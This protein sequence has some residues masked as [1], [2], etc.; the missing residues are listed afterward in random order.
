MAKI[1][2]LPKASKVNKADRLTIL[3]D[4]KVKTITKSSLLKD[5]EAKISRLAG[6]LKT[7]NKTTLAH[8]VSKNSPS[9]TKPVKGKN[10][11]SADHLSTKSYVDKN[12]SHMIRKDGS[13]PLT[14]NLSYSNKSEFS[15]NDLVDKDFVDTQLK[16]TLKKIQA[17][18]GKNGYPQASAGDVILIDTNYNSFATDGPEIQGGDILI[19]LSDSTGGTHGEVGNQFAIVNTNVVLATE[20][21]AG[22][23]K[24]STAQEI[25]ELSSDDSVI[26]PLKLKNVIEATAAYNRTEVV[27]SSYVLTEKDRGVIGVDSRRNGVTLTLPAINSLKN[28]KL[29]KYRIKDEYKSSVKYP[30]IIK[31]SSSDTIQGN[32]FFK[33]SS[34][35]GSIKL[36]NNGTDR[37]FI[38]NNLPT[39][40]DALK[41]KS[42]LTDNT[43]TGERVAA[44]AT[45]ETLMSIAVDL[46]E[47]PVGTSF[48]LVASCAFA[49]TANNKTVKLKIDGNDLISSATAEAAPNNKFG[50]IESTVLHLDTAKTVAYS[51]ALVGTNQAVGVSNLLDID[52]ER[53][54]T[55]TVDVTAATAV[56]DIN[57]YSFQVIPLK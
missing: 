34:N 39:D 26:S 22:I 18:D 4:G 30:I 14:N 49:G 31:T 27:L 6:Q 25:E 21:A 23:L 51:T 8:T 32:N 45:E 9:F 15:S 17:K 13:I 16:S 44:A 47:Y 35:G 3:Q 33:L 5:L 28:P 48:K 11:T 55:V 36:Y 24:K 42:V 54:L 56:S 10:P 57:L 53:T 40:L 41:V 46:K 1:S 7:F 38:E 52:W 43:T 20:E 19:C 37:W 2:E 50:V 12:L 29:V